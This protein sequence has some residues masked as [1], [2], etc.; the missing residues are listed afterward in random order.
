MT[1]CPVLLIVVIS[2]E[3]MH[4]QEQNL[5]MH[6]QHKKIS[7]IN[8]L[9]HIHYHGIMKMHLLFYHLVHKYTT[10]L[11]MCLFEITWECY[12]FW[13]LLLTLSVAGLNSI[14]W[15]E[16]RRKIIWKVYGRKWSRPNQVLSWNSPE[17][18]GENHENHKSGWPMFQPRFKPSTSQIWMKTNTA[19]HSVLLGENSLAP[20]ITKLRSYK[21]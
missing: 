13:V 17:V 11:L 3:N 12:F 1:K 18:T 10:S 20:H 15:M 19:T 5:V 6:K 7:Y 21:M 4:Y 9:K 8:C 16:D 2:T 14:E